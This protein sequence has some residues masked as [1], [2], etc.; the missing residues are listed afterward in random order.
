VGDETCWERVENRLL[1]DAEIQSSM[2]WTLDAGGF[3]L[4]QLL[5]MEVMFL[6]IRE[7]GKEGSSSRGDSD[8]RRVDSMGL[9]MQ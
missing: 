8:L 3:S 6:R 5:G 4:L 9:G 1:V 7:G 2:G